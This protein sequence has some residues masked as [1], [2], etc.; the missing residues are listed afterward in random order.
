MKLIT[1]LTTLAFLFI[2]LFSSTLFAQDVE[3]KINDI[4]GKVNKITIATETDEFT[5]EGDDAAKLFKK[6][7]SS[8]NSFVWHSTD[9]KGNKKIVFL[10][11]DDEEHH[12]EVFGGDDE[13]LII[14]SEDIDCEMDGMHK[15]VKV[16]VEDGNKKVT[17]TTTENGEEKTEIYEGAEAD[18]YIDEMKEKH[19]DD[20]DVFIEKDTDGKVKKKKIIIEKKTEKDSD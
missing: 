20:M 1:K 13:D 9:K 3:E 7:K 16:E 15:K 4:D 10:D 11:S 14:I 18:K 8:A 6:M 5:F 17:V 19:H 12:I 2:F